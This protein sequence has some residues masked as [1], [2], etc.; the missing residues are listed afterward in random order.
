[1]AISAHPWPIRSL[2]NL[3]RQREL[4][5]GMLAADLIGFQR[6]GALQQ[7]WRPS[8]T[9]SNR[10]SIGALRRQPPRHVT[11]VRP[12]PIS[13]RLQRRMPFM[14]PPNSRTWTAPTCSATR[15]WSNVHGDR[16]GCVWTIRRVSRSDFGGI[17]QLLEEYPSYRESSPSFRSATPSSTRIKRYQDSRAR[18]KRGPPDQSE[19]PVGNWKPLSYSSAPQPPHTTVL[20]GGALLHGHCRYTMAEPGGEEFVASR[21]DEQGALILSRFTGGQS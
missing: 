15:G 20:P 18:W 6:A 12:F 4:L 10:A 21:E 14:R 9:R 2:W 5:D 3:P 16:S 11:A 7:F 1:V 8:T 17:E 13:S 19:L